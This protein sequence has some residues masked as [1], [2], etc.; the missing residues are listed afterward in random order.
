MQ[1]IIQVPCGK[2]REPMGS[3]GEL[4]NGFGVDPVRQ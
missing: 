4:I 2:A 1:V 3:M